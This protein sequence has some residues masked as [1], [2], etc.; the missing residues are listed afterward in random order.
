MYSIVVRH[1]HNLLSD[2]PD[3]SRPHLAPCV[4]VT[5]WSIIFSVLCCMS[6]RICHSSIDGHLGHYHLFPIVNNA[7][8]NTGVQISLCVP[9]FGLWGTY[10]GVGTK[11]FPTVAASYVCT[12]NARGFPSLHILAILASPYLF[13][14][15]A[16]LV[17]EGGSRGEFDHDLT[18][19]GISSS[20]LGHCSAFRGETSVQ[21]LC[22]FW[23]W[24]VCFVVVGLCGFFIYSKC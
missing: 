15:T 19:T 20:A 10:S 17:G 6:S 1:L 3:E 18:T 11:L 21:V 7:A 4:V 2:P 13:L 23:D 5:V 9:A 16:I 8:V 22:P 14:V 12:G 24:G